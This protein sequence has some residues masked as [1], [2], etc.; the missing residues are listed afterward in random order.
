MKFVIL[1]VTVALAN[2]LSLSIEDLE[3]IAWKKKFGKL[4][5]SLKE[6][7][8]R[9]EIWLTNWKTV[10][11]HN[12]L[13]DQGLYNYRLGMNAFADLKNEEYKK[14]VLG[15]CLRNTNSTKHATFH[16][17]SFNNIDF[18]DRVDWRDKGYVTPVKNQE[19]C[20]SC[21]AFSA[22]GSLEGQ[23]FRNTGNLV[24]LSE[25]QLVDCSGDYGNYGCDGGLMDNA[26]RYIITSGGIDSEESYPYTAKEGLCSFNPETIGA[27]CN[28]YID[29]P[30]GSEAYLQMAVADNGPISVAIDAGHLSFQ[31][32]SSGVYDEPLCS[33]E[34]LN[35]GVLVIGYGTLHGN[36]YWLVKNSW[37]TDW[38]DEGFIYMSRNKN[39][40]CGIASAASFPVV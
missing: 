4:Y 37:G 13:A 34:E 8:Y 28:G 36:D 16:S 18:P 38:G 32:Y 23:H 2:A 33:S 30:K 40:Q 22:T 11:V 1:V 7:D 39:N 3:W 5:S 31:L 10:I 25:Q 35:H 27:V 29:L 15:N 26:F 20:G 21:W 12:M 6:V 9:K 17:L 19:N 14:L 24:S